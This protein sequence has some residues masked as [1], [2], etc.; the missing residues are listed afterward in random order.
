MAIDS[1]FKVVFDCRYLRNIINENQKKDVCIIPYTF[2]A[3]PKGTDQRA[4]DILRYLS[5]RQHMGI[6]KEPLEMAA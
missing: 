3:P 1:D 2:A 4:C 5:L 6:R